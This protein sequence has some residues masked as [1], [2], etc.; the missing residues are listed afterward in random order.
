MLIDILTDSRVIALVVA[1]IG[2]L[3]IIIKFMSIIMWKIGK[4]GFD[5]WNI[6][7]AEKDIKVKENFNS[8][9]KSI[10]D[11]SASLDHGLKETKNEITKLSNVLEGHDNRIEKIETHLKIEE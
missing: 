3:I 6:V 10:Q 11:F 8:L 5:Q 9:N 2:A 7:Q 1:F 4:W